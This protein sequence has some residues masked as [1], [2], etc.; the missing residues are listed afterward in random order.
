MLDPGGEPP[1]AHLTGALPQPFHP[2]GREGL[3]DHAGI[4]VKPFLNPVRKT[5][6]DN[7]L[8]TFKKEAI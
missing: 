2:I 1:L 4:T 5:V 6:A 3:W 8:G 7:P